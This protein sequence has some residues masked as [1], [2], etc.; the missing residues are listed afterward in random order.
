M[1]KNQRQY[2]LTKNNV[3]IFGEALARLKGE[4][5][6]ADVDP[7]MFKAQ[8]DGIASQLDTL[9]AEIEEYEAKPDLAGF[10][11]STRED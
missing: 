3:A 5:C 6:P 4:E 7:L 1:I 8:R 10:G 2:Y 11:V 9:V